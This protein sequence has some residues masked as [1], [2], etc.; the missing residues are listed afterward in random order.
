[1][2]NIIWTACPRFIIR[3]I[4]NLKLFSEYISDYKTYSK[5]ALIAGEG[6]SRNQLIGIIIFRTHAIEKGLSHH[7]FRPEFGKDSLFGSLK[8]HLTEYRRL[9]Y[10]LQ[11]Q[12]ITAAISA[13]NEYK[14]KHENQGIAI[15]WFDDLFHGWVVPTPI[16]SGTKIVQRKKLEDRSFS[17]LI[18]SRVSVR[19]FGPGNVKLEEIE[20]AIKMSVKTPSVCNRQPWKVKVISSTDMISKVLKIQGGFNGYDLPNKLLL[21]TVETAFFNGRNERNEPYIDG[22]LFTMSLLYALE[23][24]NIASVALNAMFT[25]NRAR[26]VANILNLSESEMLI[27]FIAVGEYPAQAVVPK[28]FRGDYRDL[29]TYY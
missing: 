25:T 13:L 16:L 27:T 15:P 2:K 10:D 22:G 9:G 12:Y 29:I 3:F 11:N 17:D 21:V 4:L 14:K 24:K 7:D 5:Y 6:K 18:S 20:A 28:S 8:S 26:Q 1:M 23:S 19:E